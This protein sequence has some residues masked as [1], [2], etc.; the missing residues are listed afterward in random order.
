[1]RLQQV[2]NKLMTVG[3]E[4]INLRVFMTIRYI[5]W[6]T[7]YNLERSDKQVH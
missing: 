1:M 5:T 7:V 3:N 2:G 6:S 4:Q